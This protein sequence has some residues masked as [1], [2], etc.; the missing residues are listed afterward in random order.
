MNNIYVL[1]NLGEYF[2]KTNFITEVPF[3]IPPSYSKLVYLNPLTE[4]WAGFS[5]SGV[6][7]KRVAIIGFSLPEHDEYIRQPLFWFI[8]NFQSNESPISKKTKLKIVDRKST[9]WEINDYKTRYNFVDWNKADCYFDGFNDRA[10]EM[11]FSH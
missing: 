2:N 7:E 1:E 9:I 5:K 3:V 10:L 11:I 8:H 6:Y 4:F